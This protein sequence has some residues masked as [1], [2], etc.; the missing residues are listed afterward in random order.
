MISILVL[1][2]TD[3]CYHDNNN[4][5]YHYYSYYYYES[6]LIY[7]KQEYFLCYSIHIKYY[8]YLL[9]P[10]KLPFF[11]ISCPV[12]VVMYIMFDIIY[13]NRLIEFYVMKS[14]QLYNIKYLLIF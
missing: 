1:Y 11:F 10:Y 4:D 14:M 3:T 12:P 9:I 8:I 2:R 13:T 7:C 5:N 6:I